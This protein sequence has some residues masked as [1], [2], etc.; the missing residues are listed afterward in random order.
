MGKANAKSI[1]IQNTQTGEV[2]E[3]NT[4]KE[5]IEYLGTNKKTFSLWKKGQPIKALTNWNLIS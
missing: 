4:T 3:F 5:A 1:K 2:F